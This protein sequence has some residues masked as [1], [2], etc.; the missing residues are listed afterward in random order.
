Q[1]PEDS[2]HL[3]SINLGNRIAHLNSFCHDVSSL[4]SQYTEKRKFIEY[5]ADPALSASDTATAAWY[6][7]NTEH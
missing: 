1:S 4:K 3:V 5:G 2:G 6:S 7:V